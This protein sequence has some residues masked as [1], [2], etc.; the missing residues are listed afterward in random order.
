MKLPQNIPLY[1]DP[2]YRGPCPIESVE[3]ASF[4]NRLRR[5]YPD[6]YGAIA[7]HPRN[8]GL[9]KN[10]QFSAVIKHAAEGMTKG[11]ADIVIPAAPAFVCELKRQN[12]V[13]SQWQDG[14]LEYLT[15]AHN[16]GAFVCVA[17]GAKAAWEAFECWRAHHAR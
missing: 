2:S 6:S 3:Q 16:A 7:I 4:F 14:Q 5:D 9:K 1:G 17:L 10:G 15:A 13:K 12:H 11:A 8:E